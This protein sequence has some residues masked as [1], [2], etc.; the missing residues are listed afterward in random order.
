MLCF[1]K[2]LFSIFQLNIFKGPSQA[3]VGKDFGQDFDTCVHQEDG[4]IV[5][6]RSKILFFGDEND[7][8]PINALHAKVPILEALT[9]RIERELLDKRPSM[10]VPE[11]SLFHH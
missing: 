2:N 11:V 8:G 1:L 5:I 10:D 7:V 4:S 3:S 6:D 9:H